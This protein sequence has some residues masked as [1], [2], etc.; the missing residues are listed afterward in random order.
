MAAEMKVIALMTMAF[1][2]ATFFAAVFAIPSLDWDH[3]EVITPHFY[4][5]LY[6]AIPT[7]LAIMGYWYLLTKQKLIQNALTKVVQAKSKLEENLGLSSTKKGAP[8]EENQDFPSLPQMQTI[9]GS[10]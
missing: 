7:T 4:T 8:D 1:L 3:D 5:Y 6:I 9:Y 10:K 2:P